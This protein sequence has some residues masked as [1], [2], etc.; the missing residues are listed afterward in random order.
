MQLIIGISGAS[1][2]IYG[3][4]LLEVLKDMPDVETHLIMSDSAKLNIG[5]ETDWATADVKALAD[6]VHSNKDIAANIASG[7]FQTAG[8][9]VAPCAIKTL[10]A[11]ANSYADSLIVRAADVVLKERRRLVLVPRETPLHAGHCELLLK[12]CQLGAIIAPPMPALYTKPQSID[13]II[14]HHV[15]R[16]LDLF[17]LDADIVKRWQGSRQVNR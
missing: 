5:I 1:G 8:M 9:I 6:H 12:A 14:N 16:L 13:D 10:S 15:G 11:I 17:D 3:I 2:V 7:S 4:R